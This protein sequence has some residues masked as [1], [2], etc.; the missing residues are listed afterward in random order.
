MVRRAFITLDTGPERPLGLELSDTNAYE[1]ETRARLGTATGASAQG[2]KPERAA[3]DDHIKQHIH[4][5]PTRGKSNDTQQIA[6]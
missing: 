2:G 3:V 1:P 6:L 5:Y 4:P